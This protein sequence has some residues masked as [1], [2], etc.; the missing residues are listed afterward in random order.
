M[1]TKSTCLEGY[2]PTSKLTSSN[3]L[4]LEQN[5]WKTQD[6][7]MKKKLVSKIKEEGVLASFQDLQIG[8]LN[9]LLSVNKLN[10]MFDDA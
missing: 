1:T 6:W 5:L 3:L 8:A 10:R 9:R 4:F 7:L 2:V